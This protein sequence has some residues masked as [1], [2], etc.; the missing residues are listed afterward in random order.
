V[1]GAR[2]PIAL[3]SRA[4]PVEKAASLLPRCWR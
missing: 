3:T 1:M 4:D 2:C